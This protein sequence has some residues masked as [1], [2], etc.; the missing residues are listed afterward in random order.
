MDYVKGENMK[1]LMNSL[2]MLAMILGSVYNIH[3]T[4]VTNWHEF[5]GTGN[6]IQTQTPVKE[7]ET[8]IAW[9]K[10]FTSGW[11]SLSDP[12]IVNDQLFVATATNSQ[13]MK[14]D[15][16]G[17]VISQMTLA[18]SL[19]YSVNIAYGDGMVFIP[20]GDGRVQ[21]VDANTMTSLWIS[22]AVEG[23]LQ[24][25]FTY[26]NGYLYFGSYISDY[27]TYAS[28]GKFYALDVKDENPASTQE[29]KSFAWS[30]A[31]KKDTGGFNWSKA[32]IYQNTVFFAG[33]DGIV[34]ACHPTTGKFLNQYDTGEAISSAITLVN[35]Q[36]YFTT[37]A[38]NIFC[39]TLNADGT[40]GKAVSQPLDTKPNTSSTSTPT[41]YNGRVYVGGGYGYGSKG[42]ISVLDSQTLE[43]L[44][45]LETSNDVQASPL[46]TTAYSGKTI[47]YF[48]MNNEPGGLYALA[49]DLNTNSG[50][51]ASVYTPNGDAVNYCMSSAIADAYGNLYHTNDSGYLTKLSKTEALSLNS[52]G[53]LVNGNF[54]KGTQ[55]EV[56]QQSQG[57][58]I[59]TLLDQNTTFEKATLYHFNLTHESNTIEPT[60]KVA[61]TMPIP[62]GYANDRLKLYYVNADNS[63][64]EYNYQVNQGN[65]TF[66]TD[67]FST[68][69]LVQLKVEE[70]TSQTETTPQQEQPQIPNTGDQ[71]KMTL[72]I[73]I[74]G[75]AILAIIGLVVMNKKKK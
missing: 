72:Y 24:G 23:S 9:S 13:L 5:M 4:E 39:L 54:I 47:A 65:I 26:H 56:Q 73:V 36:L 74:A 71:T 22:E 34:Y 3:G 60:Q 45:R 7:N 48:T 64:V 10:D 61:V 1:K 42:F 20:L 75:A 28:N 27:V 57:N 55:L 38:G 67:H 41:V 58:Q 31:S 69:L 68:Y 15:L 51:I 66:H 53:I 63:L 17:N 30:F 62:E 37:K 2:L 16:N 44:Y 33:M 35:N 46:V 8:A 59:Q 25:R 52:N 70:P 11:D 43:T 29:T 19:G 32:V 50:T 14:L 12:I 21:A 6:V 18:S 40:F 49:D